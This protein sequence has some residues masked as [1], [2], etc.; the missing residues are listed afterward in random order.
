MV[1]FAVQVVK[2][3]E[4]TEL[5]VKKSIKPLYNWFTCTYRLTYCIISQVF[6]QIS[7]FI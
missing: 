3:R 7:I 1:L 4:P 5:K 6:E 2:V